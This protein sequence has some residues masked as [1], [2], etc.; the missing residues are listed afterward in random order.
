M[1]TAND[2]LKNLKQFKLQK[3][4]EKSL[5]K[6]KEYILDLNRGQLLHGK[7]SKD[8][9]VMSY[10]SDSYAEYKQGKNS[11]PPFGVPDLYLTGAFHK[12]FMMKIE[13]SDIVLVSKD[14]KSPELQEKYGEDIFGLTDYSIETLINKK[15]LNE[16]LSIVR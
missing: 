16:F 4:I 1:N 10:R 5:K 7:D 6:S 3:D 12:A 8:E 14:S 9:D 2:I 15:L 13:G 11:L